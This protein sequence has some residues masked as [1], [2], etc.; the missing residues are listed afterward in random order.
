MQ[1]PEHANK[2][3]CVRVP[4]R[5]V[6]GSALL[7]GVQLA[8]WHQM[9]QEGGQRCAVSAAKEENDLHKSCQATLAPQHI[10]HGGKLNAGA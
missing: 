1:P 10:D 2:P 3:L 9:S 7:A 4:D 8:T 5:A 6:Q